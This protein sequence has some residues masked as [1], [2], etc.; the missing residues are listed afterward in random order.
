M[1]E[2]TGSARGRSGAGSRH[3]AMNSEDEVLDALKRIMRAVDMHSRRL[4]VQHGLSTPQ[5][6]C[7]RELARG[8]PVPSGRLAE[9]VNLSPATL[10]GILDRLEARGF[11]R[12]VR[13][14]DD[15]R[16]VMVELSAEGSALL[17]HAPSPM[18]DD[19]LR[20]FRALSATQQ[21]DIA[22]VLHKLGRM[23]TPEPTEP[24]RD[25]RRPVNGRKLRDESV[26]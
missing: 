24:A 18:Q 21:A 25:S 12:R 26:S 1:A 22:R 13:Q 17:A 6:I 5:L 19:F 2:M 8:G 15:K 11:I 23:M 7:L 4:L 16:R 9:Q 10:S 3:G 20:R 14:L